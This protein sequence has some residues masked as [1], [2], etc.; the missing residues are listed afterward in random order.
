MKVVKYSL[1]SSSS[2][3]SVLS[4]YEVLTAVIMDSTIFWD[5]TPFS[6]MN[7]NRSFGGTCRLHLEG[8]K[9]NQARNHGDAG[10]RKSLVGLFFGRGNGSDMVLRNVG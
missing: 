10:S 7:V 9:I 8:R 2:S 3:S 1:L 4:G 5:I 6:S